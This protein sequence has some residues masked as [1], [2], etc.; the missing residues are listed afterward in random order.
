MQGCKYF[1]KLC[2]YVHI[3]EAEFDA[4]YLVNIFLPSKLTLLCRP[5]NRFYVF[6]VSLKKLNALTLEALRLMRSV[7]V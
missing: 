5:T 3:T 2:H 6:Y 1:H 4:G 7:N